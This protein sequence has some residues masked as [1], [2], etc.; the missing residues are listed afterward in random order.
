IIGLRNGV[1]EDEK[2]GLKRQMIDEVETPYECSMFTMRIHH[3]GN[4]RRFPGR[5]YVGGKEGIFDLVDIDVF[6]ARV[7]SDGDTGYTYENELLFYHYLRSMSSL[8]DV[9]LFAL[10]CDEDVRCPSV[11]ERTLLFMEAHDRVKKRASLKL[12]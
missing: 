7:R 4:F 3:G 12:A 1:N 8:V 6:Y 2:S 11:E 10:S 5:Q 9:G